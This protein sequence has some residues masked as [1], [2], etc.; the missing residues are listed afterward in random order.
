V[1]S[2]VVLYAMLLWS[3]Q[4]LR[5]T[6]PLFSLLIFLRMAY[7]CVMSPFAPQAYTWTNAGFIGLCLLMQVFATWLPNRRTAASVSASA[8]Q[9][10][11][12][13]SSQ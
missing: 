4:R 10:V 11:S 6:V 12:P 8:A 3:V 1:A 2:I 13:S 5:F 9:S 7:V